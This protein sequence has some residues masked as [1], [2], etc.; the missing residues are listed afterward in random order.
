M[1]GHVSFV[2]AQPWGWFQPSK[3]HRDADD[4]A[5]AE[6]GGGGEEGGGGGGRWKGGAKVCVC[7]TAG[8]S[9]MAVVNPKLKYD[10]FKQAMKPVL[11]QYQCPRYV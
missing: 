7:C 5:L 4:V 3:R 1:S 11:N 10:W 9:V 6:G 8:R 2:R